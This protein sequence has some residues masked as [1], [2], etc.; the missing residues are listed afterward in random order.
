VIHEF[1]VTH[2]EME[3][4]LDIL[5]SRQRALSFE[6]SNTEAHVAKAEL[7][8]RERDI[9]RLIERLRAEVAPIQG[10]AQH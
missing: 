5:Q 1:K 9:D 7:R 10:S 8:K 2:D 6:I 4:L 3:L